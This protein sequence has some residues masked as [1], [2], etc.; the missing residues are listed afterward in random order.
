MTDKLSEWSMDLKLEKSMLSQSLKKESTLLL[1]EKTRESNSGT[2]MK[3]SAT[4]L[5]LDILET[6]QE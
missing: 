5:E 4:G 6:S 1:E 2:T 3:E